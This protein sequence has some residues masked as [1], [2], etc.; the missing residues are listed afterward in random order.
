MGENFHNA[1]ATGNLINTGTASR[2]RRVADVKCRISINERIP[3][4]INNF[5]N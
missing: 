3:I 1:T 5:R 4:H 2:H